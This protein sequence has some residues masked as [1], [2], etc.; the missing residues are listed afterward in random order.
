MSSG[1]AGQ[2]I[3]Q[4]S[5]FLTKNLVEFMSD[6]GRERR[7]CRRGQWDLMRGIVYIQRRRVWLQVR[8]RGCSCF[9]SY[10]SD[11]QSD[12]FVLAG[13]AHSINHNLL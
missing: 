11:G 7:A 12:I 4:L 9:Y 8:S 3:C 6:E 13:V 5:L 10:Q 2:E 1:D